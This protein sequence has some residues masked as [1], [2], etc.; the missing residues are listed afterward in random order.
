MIKKHVFN[1]PAWLLATLA[2]SFPAWP[3]AV[4]EP[5]VTTLD[6]VVITG[7]SPDSPLTFVTDPKKP[8]QP[9]PASDGTDYLKTIPGF[10]AIRNGGS[11]GDPVLR[12]MFGSRLNILTNGAMMLGACPARMDAPTSYISPETF[13]RLTVIKGPQTVLWGPGASAGTIKFD[14]DAPGFTEPGVLFDGTLTG[15]SRGRNDQ[16]ADLA[17]GTEKFYARVTANHSHSQDYKDGDGNI[18][19]SRWDKWNTDVALGLTP[20]ADTLIELSA[21]TG[22]GEARYAGRGMDGSQFKRESLGLRFEKRNMDGMLKKVEAQLYYNYAD[23]VM[24]NYSLRPFKPSGSMSMPMASNVDRATWGGRYAGTLDLAETLSLVAGMDY[25]ENRHRKRSAMGAAAQSYD[26]QPWVKDAEFS[27]TGLFGELTWQAS[28]AG[29]VI[30]GARVDW[31]SAKDFRKTTGSGMAQMPN[32]SAGKRRSDTLPSGFLRYERELDGLPATVYVGLG[33]VERFPD[34]WE[35]FS[36]TRGPAGSANAFQGVKPEKTT[37]LD[38]GAQYKTEKL[39][40]WFSGYAGYVN[41]FILFDYS[42]SSMMSSTSQ[43]ANVDARILGGELGASYKLAAHWTVG[44]TLAY[45]WGENRS[46]GSALPQIPPLEA[47]LSASY[48]SGHWSAGALWRVAA[49]QKRYAL[50]QGN[51]VSKDFGPSAG[52]GVFSLNGGY[53]VDK[54]LRFTFG[55]DNLLNKTYS[56][57]LNLAGNAGFGYAANTAINEPG[58]T[59]WASVNFKY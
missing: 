59:I 12:G 7:V 41:D 2:A 28:A 27:D 14:R 47:R 9:I 25:Q 13:D 17:A 34:Y 19:A 45:A 31:A 23:H 57:H 20:D 1:R 21:G 56:E 6:A 36:P 26:S 10:S 49:A 22:D 16:A 48:E 46:G 55:V 3:Q 50:D 42:G 11:N 15:G 43:A 24:D 58:R 44:G 40:A 30:G 4:R 33:H 51:V 5:S 53:A 54:R 35:M 39:D 32:P 8:R 37:Q 29:K 52:F 18:V 38:F